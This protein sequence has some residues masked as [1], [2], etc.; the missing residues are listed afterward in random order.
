MI[1]IILKI[2]RQSS[3]IV[4]RLH[5]PLEFPT[6]GGQTSGELIETIEDFEK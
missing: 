3:K 2:T 4:V 6:K 5:S 1:V